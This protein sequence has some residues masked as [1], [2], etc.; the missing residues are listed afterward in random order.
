M[1]KGPFNI[2]IAD[3]D[4]DDLYLFAQAINELGLD[5]NL[6]QA[7][8]GV[9]VLE[10]LQTVKELPRIIILDVNMPLMDGLTALGVIRANENYKTVPIIIFSTT[11][12]PRGVRDAYRLGAS[13][14]LRKP[15]TYSDY[16][17]IIR[18]LVIGEN[19]S[20]TLQ[21]FVCQ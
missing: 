12:N 13:L 2:V 15:T 9:E 14:F 21:P 17:N 3:D 7:Q 1:N 16:L 4:E 6:S 5:A 19:N 10:I 8:T 18:A 20:D 11:E